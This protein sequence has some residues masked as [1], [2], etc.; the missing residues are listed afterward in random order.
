M[1]RIVIIKIG[2]TGDV[3]RTTVLL[4]LFA[5]DEI[6]WITAKH[7]IAV[8]PFRQPNLKEIIA[9]EEIEKS[10]VLTA[11]YDW[12][13]SLDDDYKCSALA[14]KIKTKQL[15]GAFTFPKREESPISNHS[16]EAEV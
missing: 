13:I 10:D 8:L 6:T 9:I 1:S 3:V 14:S 11:Q 4:H 16:L 12:V 2:A 7:N 15:F 5:N